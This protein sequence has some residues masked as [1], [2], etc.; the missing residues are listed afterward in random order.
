DALVAGIRLDHPTPPPFWLPPREHYPDGLIACQNGLLD[1]N[2]HTLLPHSPLFF[3]V[4]SLPFDFNPKALPPQR[5]LAL[6]DE[7]WPNDQQSKCTLQEIFGVSL[8]SDT[9][10]QK[11]FSIV[12]PTR[13]GKGTIGDTLSNLLG[14]ENVAS[15]TM[16]SLG[17]Q[18]GLAPLID[19][20]LAIVPMLGW[21][22]GK[23]IR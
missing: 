4:N 6:L 1:I 23:H 8:T 7:L 20:R 10:H 16:A 9:R 13:S 3:C 21:P 12:G 17:T 14:R 11:I 22:V 2:T 18:F 5:W 19:K 15:P